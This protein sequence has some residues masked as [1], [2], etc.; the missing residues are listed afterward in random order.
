MACNCNQR[1]AL[2]A[3]TVADQ[4]VVAEGFLDF[5]TNSVRNGCSVVHV[6]GSNSITLA[7]DG[8]YLVTPAAA[9][10]ITLQLISNGTAVPGAEATITG[11]AADIYNISFSTLVKELPSCYAIDNTTVLQ[12]Q[13]S[14]AA[15]V[16]NASITIIK[17]AQAVKD[18]A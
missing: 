7:S 2:T 16:N 5:N 8:L 13:S 17:V 3:V 10:D 11:A 6:A 9:G 18:Y 4:T 14:A 1:P 15:T 12:V